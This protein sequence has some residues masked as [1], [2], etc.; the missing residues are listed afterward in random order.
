MMNTVNT[1]L[2][3]FAVWFA[4]QVSKALQIAS[5]SKSKN[6]DKTKKVK[7]NYIPPEKRQQIIDD[8]RLF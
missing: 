4:D 1:E 3:S 7:K 5:V 8:L 2:S 6:D